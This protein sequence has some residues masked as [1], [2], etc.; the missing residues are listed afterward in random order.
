MRLSSILVAAVL[1]AA[2]TIAARP[3]EAQTDLVINSLNLQ[4]VNYDAATGLLTATGGTVT[5]TLGGLPFTTDINNFSLQQSPGNGNRCSV[6]D[7]ELGPINLALLGLHIDT[8]SICLTITAFQGRGILGD[9]LCGLAGGNLGLL[10]SPDLLSGLTAILNEALG[11]ARTAPQGQGPGGG[12]VC[13]GE[14]EVL[15]LVLGP[16]NL[17]LLGVVVHLDNCDNGPVQIC[18]SATADEG[19]LGGLLCGLAGGGPLQ[20]ITLAELLELISG[21]LDALPL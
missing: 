17:N 5:G 2:C 4:G 15:D 14:C 21:L 11:R 13:T 10:G 9:L 20:G 3:A 1:T 7:L 6:L 12:S 16:L 19:L 8:S 18:V